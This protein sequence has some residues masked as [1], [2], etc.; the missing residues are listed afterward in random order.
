MAQRNRSMSAKLGKGCSALTLSQPNAAGIRRNAPMRPPSS[1]VARLRCRVHRSVLGHEGEISILS[2]FGQSP[3]GPPFGPVTVWPLRWHVLTAHAG[4]P[5][6]TWRPDRDA[7]AHGRRRRWFVRGATGPRGAL[8]ATTAALPRCAGC[9][10]AI[11]QSPRCTVA[12]WRNGRWSA[13]ASRYS[14]TASFC[15]ARWRASSRRIPGSAI[16]CAERTTVG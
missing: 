16:Q 9:G 14:T 5:A 7:V 3:F 13:A 12:S 10:T 8:T 11:L 4:H 15:S 2:P 6:G 1:R